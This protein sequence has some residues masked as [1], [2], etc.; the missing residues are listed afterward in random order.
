MLSATLGSLRKRQE[1]QAVWND[2]MR[3]SPGFDIEGCLSKLKHRLG[4]DIQRVWAGL[5]D[6]G[7]LS[8]TAEDRRET[9]RSDVS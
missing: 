7:T 3:L 1:A 5:I 8:G 9:A 6:A 2:L 4:C